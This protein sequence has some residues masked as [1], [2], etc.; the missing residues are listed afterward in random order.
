M[1]LK[2]GAALPARKGFENP[3][4]QLVDGYFAKNKVSWGAPVGDRV[5]ARRVWLDTIGLLPPPAELAPSCAEAGVLGVLP[6][7]SG[8]AQN[9]F[10][11][12]GAQFKGQINVG[13][14]P[15]DFTYG[16]RYM[17]NGWAAYRIKDQFSVSAGVRWQIWGNIEG[18]DPNLDPTRDPAAD[19]VF[20]AGQ[21]ADRP[22]RVRERC[23][24][25][26]GR[27]AEIRHERSRW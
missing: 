16:D 22:R 27:R 10:G 17:A 18:A 11:S 21:R 14:G 5:Y 23:R 6:G 26:Y 8:Q 2:V 20:L 1:P 13:E 7:I 15:T 19:P 12:V 9:E 3:V 24:D 4:D 25:R